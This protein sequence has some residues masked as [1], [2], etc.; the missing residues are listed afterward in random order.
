MQKPQWLRDRQ[1]RERIRQRAGY[2]VMLATSV[3]IVWYV[4]GPIVALFAA[5]AAVAFWL[6]NI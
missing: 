1:A 5:G 6:I 4:F 3:G 2:A